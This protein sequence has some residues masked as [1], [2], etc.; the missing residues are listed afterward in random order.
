LRKNLEEKR[1]EVA[2]FRG[3]LLKR[4]PGP[5]YLKLLHEVAEAERQRLLRNLTMQMAQQFGGDIAQEGRAQS[6]IDVAI[7][8]LEGWQKTLTRVREF[9]AQE[10]GRHEARRKE[11]YAIG[12]RSYI[13]DPARFPQAAAIEEELYR[14]YKPAVRLT[15]LGPDPNGA[16][17]AGF[18]WEP[19]RG[20]YAYFDYSV[21][22]KEK[23][24]QLNPNTKMP[25]TAPMLGEG[26][27]AE[28]IAKA[29]QDGPFRLLAEQV[30]NDKEARI[31]AYIPRLYNQQINFV[32]RTM[33]PHSRALVRFDGIQSVARQEEHYFAVDYTSDDPNVT[34][35]YNWFNTNWSQ[36]NQVYLQSESDVACTYLTLY[37]GI[38]LD[39]IRGATECEPQYRA[40]ERS[41]GCL[42]LFPEERLAA[43]YEMQVVQRN[44]PEWRGVRR[45]HPDVVVGLGASQRVRMFALGMVSGIIRDEAN[46]RDREHFLVL[47]DR[48]PIQL[49]HTDKITNYSIMRDHD[50]VAARLL[51]AFHTYMLIEHEIGNEYK[52]IPYDEVMPAVEAWLK[53]TYGDPSGADIDKLLKQWETSTDGPGLYELFNNESRDPRFRDLGVVLLL[54]L[55]AWR[56][57]FR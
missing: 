39:H 28:G 19:R 42:H 9:L 11:K 49:S 30:R 21:M 48:E 4:N 41:Q 52:P 50:R 7:Q 2:N 57:R 55:F 54:E 35:F 22:T 18:Y 31:A 25:V 43:D 24:F 17:G 53:A 44:K 47:P 23:S 46:A 5:D 8:E 36:M 20:S 33:N 38:E 10:R 13:T 29:W 37:H 56:R 45:L 15:L 34:G 1:A 32:N 6:V 14:R 3:G 40:M 26:S 27:G 12:V 51:Q 16:S